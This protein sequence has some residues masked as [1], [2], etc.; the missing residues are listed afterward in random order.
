MSSSTLHNHWHIVDAMSMFV[1]R[2]GEGSRG[3]GSWDR[4]QEVVRVPSIRETLQRIWEP[5]NAPFVSTLGVRRPRE[6]KALVQSHAVSLGPETGLEP[7]GLDAHSS[8]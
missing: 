1:D 8:I 7:R 2:I 3:L 4:N 6:E 5:L